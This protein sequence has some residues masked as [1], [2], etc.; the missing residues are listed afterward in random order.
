[1]KLSNAITA[2]AFICCIGNT[3]TAYASYKYEVDR[4]TGTET[5][6]YTQKGSGCTQTKG[7]QGRAN[8]CLYINSTESDRYP[9]IAIM[10]INDNWELLDT[11][12]R[13]K[14]APA[15]ITLTNGQVLR[16]TIPAALQTD[17]GSG[18]VSEWVKLYL[19]DSDVPVGRVR[20]LEVQYGS[21]EFKLTPDNQATCALNFKKNC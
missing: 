12:A 20:T 1:M 18:Y 5:A 4:F 10:K 15:I 17:V 3:A 6:S 8:L 21:A 16:T 19:G 2:L 7:I 9:I 11:A 14:D 13:E